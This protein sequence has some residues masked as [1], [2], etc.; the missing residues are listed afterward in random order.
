MKSILGAV[1]LA[2]LLVA[3]TIEG[4]SD[5]DAAIA[6]ESATQD[7]IE[8]VAISAN[9]ERAEAQIDQLLAEVSK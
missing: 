3:G 6:T 1:L 4:P 8:S 7:A 2:A 5:M 9:A